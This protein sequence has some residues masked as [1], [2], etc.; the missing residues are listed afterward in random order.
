MVEL[1]TALS[2]MLDLARVR[3]GANTGLGQGLHQLVLILADGRFHEKDS[4]RRMVAV[5]SST[6]SLC[7]T[8][9][10][11][12]CLVLHQ[13]QGSLHEPCCIIHMMYSNVCCALLPLCVQKT[14]CLF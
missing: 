9:H 4:L 2:H 3:A 13:R 5:R 7:R 11:S 10:Q 6:F 14:Q 12:A 1:L 8:E